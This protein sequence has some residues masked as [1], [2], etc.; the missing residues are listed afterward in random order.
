MT[1]YNY[2]FSIYH[3][4]KCSYAVKLKKIHLLENVS[5]PILYK[6][7]VLVTSI[8]IIIITIII[9]IIIIEFFS[10]GMGLRP[11]GMRLP[12]P[13]GAYTFFY[14][15]RCQVEILVTG[16]SLVQKGVAECGV[17]NCMWY[18]N[19][20]DEESHPQYGLSSHRKLG[21]GAVIPNGTP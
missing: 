21:G 13:P 15:V 2:V 4:C 9:I 12:I 10:F 6:H 20:D 18:P 17:F 7:T 14:R 5:Q 19:L 16:R 3:L 1:C 11:L 8:I